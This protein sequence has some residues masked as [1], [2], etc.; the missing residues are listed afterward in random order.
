MIW[1]AA[2]FGIVAVVLALAACSSSDLGTGM[3]TVDRDYTA[4]VKEAHDAALATLKAENLQIES[5]KADAL[6]ANIVA[7]RGASD[8]KVLVDIKGK[9]KGKSS[10][11]VRVQPGDKAQATML[12]DHIEEKL[13]PAAK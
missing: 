1:K 5:D 3:N 7:K 12:Q 13:S 6:G 2:G 8:D 4:S 10:V 11:S 9:E